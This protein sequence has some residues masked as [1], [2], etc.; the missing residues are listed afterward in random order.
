MSLHKPVEVKAV[1]PYTLYVRF[2]D[3]VE[4]LADV[5][6]I[7]GKGVFEP[8]V[9]YEVFEKVSIDESGAISWDENMD[10]CSDSVYESIKN[11]G[12]AKN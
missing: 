3:G 7:A 2:E 6:D 1:R 10:I 12:G 11:S 5:S 4:G 9:R 8:L